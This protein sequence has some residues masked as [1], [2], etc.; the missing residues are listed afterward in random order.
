MKTTKPRKRKLTDVIE[1][2]ETAAA[3]PDPAMSAILVPAAVAVVAA[4][5]RVPAPAPQAVNGKP[6]A[7]K[8]S[9]W[10]GLGSLVLIVV[11]L[12]F[13]GPAAAGLLMLFANPLG[14]LIVGLAIWK[15][16]DMS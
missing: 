6:P 14:L 4:P 11:M 1:H 10:W 12:M 5:V 2:L 13:A 15:L 3:P 7:K 16:W 8:K 9:S